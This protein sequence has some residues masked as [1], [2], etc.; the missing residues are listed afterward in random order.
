ML[1]LARRALSSVVLEKVRETSVD[2]AASHVE[3]Q[4]EEKCRD[5][6]RVRIYKLMP[7]QHIP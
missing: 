4:V 5:N 2:M 3:R 7:S 1:T 6:W